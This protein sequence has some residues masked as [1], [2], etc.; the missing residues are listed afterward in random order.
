MILD[1][2]N[3]PACNQESR[4][5]NRK[6]FSLSVFVSHRDAKSRSGAGGVDLDEPFL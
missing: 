3:E 5:K 2:P 6:S 1:F 4:I